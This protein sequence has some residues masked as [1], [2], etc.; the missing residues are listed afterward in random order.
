MFRYTAND[1]NGC[2]IV[3]CCPY[4]I[5]MLPSLSF[6]LSLVPTCKGELDNILIENLNNTVFSKIKIDNGIFENYPQSS[7]L[8]GL[9][10]GLHTITIQNQ[11]G[12]TEAKQITINPAL[13]KQCSSISVTKKQK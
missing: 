11:L 9:S 2:S 3:Q 8:S 1:I 4:N 5:Q 7:T 13:P 10:V 12:C 6:A